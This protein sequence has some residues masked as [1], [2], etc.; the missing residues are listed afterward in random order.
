MTEPIDIS[1]PLQKLCEL[2]GLTYNHTAD[3]TIERN[4][5]TATVYRVNERGEKYIDPPG[6]GPA[7]QTRTIE[8]TT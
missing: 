1:E 3:L 2:L 7:T 4:T 6:N 5:V 8:I